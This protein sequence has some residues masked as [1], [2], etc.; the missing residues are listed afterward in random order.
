M[1]TQKDLIDKLSQKINN[2]DFQVFKLQIQTKME[3]LE[4]EVSRFE[5]HNVT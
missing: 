2:Q 4:S 5:G 1:P 3:T